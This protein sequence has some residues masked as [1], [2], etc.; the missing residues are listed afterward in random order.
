[1]ARIANAERKVAPKVETSTSHVDE[2][3]VIVDRLRKEDPNYF[4]GF[5]RHNVTD[6]DLQRE[7]FEKVTD[8]T[9]A[10]LHHNGD[11]VV[12]RP[13]ELHKAK[14]ASRH[15]ASY[16]MVKDRLEGQDRA[17]KLTQVA[18]KKTP[19]AVETKY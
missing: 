18:S 19:K 16:E 8:G 9:G 11:P 12:R 7:G 15:N 17:G 3:K 2:R 4:Y 6:Y 13:M 5:H 1:M 14:R 10:V